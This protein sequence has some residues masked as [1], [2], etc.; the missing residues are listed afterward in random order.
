MTTIK[1]NLLAGLLFFSG[2]LFAQTEG[3]HEMMK[4]SSSHEEHQKMNMHDTGQMHHPE[5][6]PMSHAFSLNLPMNRNGSGTGW[7]P[8]NSPMF[9]YMMHSRKWMYMIHGSIFLT[10]N[11][12][13][14]GDAGTRGDTK[15]YAPNWIMAMGQT[16]VGERGL[17]RF[18]AMMSLDPLTIGGAG[19]PLLF[20]SGE[21][22]NG[23]PLVDHQH[24]HDLFSEL[25]V[26]YTHSLS[27]DMDVFA[28]VGY[29][30]EP[31]FGP[32]AFMHRPSSLYNP[33]API[34]HHWQDATHILFGV[35]TLGFRYKNFKLDGSL[36]TGTEPDEDRYN[37][38]KPRFNSWSARLS[39]NPSPAW[40]LQV[41]QAWVNDAHASGPPE[42][43]NKSTASAIHSLRW[44]SGN[45][46]NTTAVWGY[47]HTVQGHHPDSHSILLESALSL[48][49]TAIYGK[50]EWVEKSTG[51][52]LLDESIYEDGELFPINAFTLGVQ[53]NL[54]NV[55]HTNVSVGVQ[56]SLYAA[57]DKLNPVYGNNP[58]GL[59][60][61]L[62]IYPRMMR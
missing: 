39:Y 37:F 12:Q 15:F 49:K 20:Q 16:K 11:K 25:S 60:A 34:G 53:Q 19:Y 7:L 29:P 28:Y 23:V 26:A 47:N 13:D 61:Y 1:F 51:N 43:V 24:P 30:G 6:V 2:S 41:S 35:G 50:Y 32:V 58:I 40:A 10:Y 48:N 8:D 56:G 27:E 33:D 46:I 22:W 17:F 5:D 59:Q 52:L 42:D 54:V 36:F 57:P 62:R 14:V 21:T 9:G 18:S 4:D 44:D 3:H 45:S 31:A 38:D 55:L